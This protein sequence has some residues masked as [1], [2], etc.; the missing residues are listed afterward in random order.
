MDILMI[1]NLIIMG[2]TFPQPFVEMPQNVLTK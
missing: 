1:K 2:M